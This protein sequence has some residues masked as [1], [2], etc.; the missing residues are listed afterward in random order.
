MAI[1]HVATD[2]VKRTMKLEYVRTRSDSMSRSLEG[3]Q[4][5]LSHLAKPKPQLRIL[6]QESANLIQKQHSL[7]WV[8]IGMRNPSDRLFRF[9][10]NSGVRPEAWS[11]FKQ[12]VYRDESFGLS[13]DDYK[14]EAI[15]RLTRLYLEEENP[16]DKADLQALNRPALFHSTRRASDDSLEADYV[17][18]HIRGPDDELLGWIEYSGTFMGKLPD[19]TTIRCIEVIS[20]ILGLAM[21]SHNRQL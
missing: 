7:R 4:M 16:L 12:K 13:T 3:F 5:L 19:S 18:T 14:S 15:S 21:S 9:E 2:D 11:V 1:G 20:S 6:L 8:A 10:V 17:D